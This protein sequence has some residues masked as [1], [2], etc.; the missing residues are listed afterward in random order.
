MNKRYKLIEFE[1]AEPELYD[2]ENDPEE[3]INIAKG[4]E[5]LMKYFRTLYKMR[6]IQQD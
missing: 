5:E 3:Q 4:N 2:M 1:D 6:P